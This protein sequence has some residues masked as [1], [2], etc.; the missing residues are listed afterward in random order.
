MR[1]EDDYFYFD[2]KK[3]FV[4][5]W[6]SG[7]ASLVNTRL[8]KG[9][10]AIVLYLAQYVDYQ[11]CIA[12]NGDRILTRSDIVL[13]CNVSPD[14]VKKDMKRLRRLGILTEVKIEDRIKIIVNPFVYCRGSKANAT[15]LEIFKDTP[16]YRD[17]FC[18]VS[19]REV[20]VIDNL[21][22]LEDT[23]TFTKMWTDNYP[24]VINQKLTG[25]EFAVLILCMSYVKR[26]DGVLVHRN[27]K[28]LTFENIV[29]MTNL[30]TWTVEKAINKFINIHFLANTE[31]VRPST[32]EIIKCYAINPLL[33]AKSEKV[34]LEVY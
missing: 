27:G 9:E 28:L 26:L 5:L 6:D 33:C 14:A 30:S 18:K 8:S 3:R 21:I 23:V 1:S 20:D 10:W 24:N 29:G 16:Q 11:S 22:K 17:S 19:K 12:K 4:K 34:E 13:G 15:L 7:I 32:G 25:G 2:K 31:F